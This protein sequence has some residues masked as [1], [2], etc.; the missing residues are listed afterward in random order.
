MA[1]R[2]FIDS[3]FTLVKR[4]VVLYAA[5]AVDSTTPTLQRWNYPAFSGG[6]TARTYTAAPSGSVP[7]SAG[8]FPLQYQYGAEGVLSVARTGVGLWTLR[9]QDNYQR[10]LQVAGQQQL[11]GGSGNILQVTIN[12]TLTSVGA[13]GGALIGLGLLSAA[14]T[15]ADPTSGSVVLLSITLQDATEP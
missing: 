1:Q 9:L 13:A 7:S 8:N 5:V 12:S 4:Q 10:V 3:N 15:L 11:A 6:P 14:S 2:S